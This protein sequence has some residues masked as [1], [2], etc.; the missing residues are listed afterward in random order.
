MPFRTCTSGSKC[1]AAL[2]LCLVAAAGSAG[3]ELAPPVRPSAVLR[4]ELMAPVYHRKFGT[5]T[6]TGPCLALQSALAD[7]LRGILRHE[8]AFVDWTTRVPVADTVRVALVQQ[9]AA[10]GSDVM[11]ELALL[12]RGGVPSEPPVRIRFERWLDAMQRSPLV[13]ARPDSVRNE[14]APR[15]SSVLDEQVDEIVKGVFRRLPLR[16]TV[17]LHS[18]E[19]RVD[20]RPD[21]LNA[22]PDPR[23]AFLVRLPVRR[24]PFGAVDTADVHLDE[25]G[26]QATAFVCDVGEVKYRGKA[27]EGPER[28]DILA[29]AP[30]VV[31]GV[32][33]RRYSPGS[34]VR[35]PNGMVAPEGNEP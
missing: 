23:P 16:A 34:R 15:L 29:H 26:A 10:P 8:F 20:L 5:P 31:T 28:A 25:C 21:T 6:C 11:L 19:A 14:W 27:R 3:D 24:G 9:S 30:R 35:R 12:G 1:A 32:Y 7:T 4:V 17:E 2:A 33:V 18:T 22:S 13:Y